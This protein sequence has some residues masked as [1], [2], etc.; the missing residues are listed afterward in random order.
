MP[1]LTAKHEQFVQLI[2]RGARFGWT[3]GE[4]YQRAG[5]RATG[6]TAEVNASRLLKKADIQARLAELAAPAFKKAQVTVESLLAELE[7]NIAG[8]TAAQQH[9]A[10]NGAIQLMGKLRG[11]LTDR[12]EIGAPGDF[13]N[14][15]SVDAA[16]SDFGN[17]DPGIALAN[18][19][20]AVLDMRAELEARAAA[21]AKV[22]D[23]PTLAPRTSNEAAAALA[24]LRPVPRSRR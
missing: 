20:E 4:A 12:V 1:A 2:A 19:E 11:L 6:H 3:Q 8:A 14:G 24:L 17:G 21:Y 7:A 22:I 13:G 23:T 5:F 10:V 15:F 16:I 9:G 18:F